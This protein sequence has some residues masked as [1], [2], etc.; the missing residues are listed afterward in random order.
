MLKR[1]SEIV[2]RPRWL[3]VLALATALAAPAMGFA[4]PQPA[5]HSAHQPATAPADMSL[6]D[7]V[8][9]LR[10]KV[11]KLETALQHKQTGMAARSSIGM[12][13]MGGMGQAAGGSMPGMA[14]SS[15]A[16]G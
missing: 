12:Q 15:G 2:R 8:T 5:D 11:S 9:E 7:Q 16:G 10:A 3:S 4:Q 6:A 1:E 14:P 13:P